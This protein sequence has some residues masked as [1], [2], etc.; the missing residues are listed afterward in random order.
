MSACIKNYAVLLAPLEAAVAGK[1][2]SAAILWTNELGNCF[3]QAKEALND[4][5]TIYVPKPTDKLDVYSDYS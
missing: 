5:K 4:I 3:K 2:S 1:S